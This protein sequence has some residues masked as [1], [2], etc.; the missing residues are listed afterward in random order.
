MPPARSR[1]GSHPRSSPTPERRERLR[2]GPLTGLVESAPRPDLV[3]RPRQIVPGMLHD[4]RADFRPLPC[5]V[6]AI[7]SRP[8]SPAPLIL[9]MVVRHR[10]EL[11]RASGFRAWNTPS[12]PG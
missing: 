2:H 11:P 10:G 1:A 4:P 9:R 7:R 3:A 6:A 5:A 8:P 12:R